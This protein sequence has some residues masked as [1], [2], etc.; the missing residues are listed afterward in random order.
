MQ[1]H[2]AVL[3]DHPVHVAARGHHA[4][5]G[6]EFRDDARDLAAPA[7]GRQ[8]DDRLAAAREGGA[9]DEV[10]LPADARV[11]AMP[12][13]VGH[14][15]ARQVHLDGRVDGHHA[16]IAPDDRRVVGAVTGVKFDR[17][18]VVHEVEQPAGADDEARRRTSGVH[19]LV[20]VGDDAALDQVDEA[21]GEHL[22]VHAEVVLV[23]QAREHRVG[24]GADAHLQGGAVLDEA[25]DDFADARLDRILRAGAVLGKRAIRV[26]ERVDAV[27]RNGGVAVRARHLL[28]D[29][30]DDEARAVDGGARRI[31]RRAERAEAVG[32]GRG[33]L[34]E[35]DVE[36]HASRR[37]QRR[38]VREEDRH[39]IGAPL[40]DGRA[41]AGAG[42]QGDGVEALGLAGRRPRGVTREV[43]VVETDVLEVVARGEGFEQGRGR[44]GRSLDEYPRAAAHEGEGVGGRDGA[45]APVSV[46]WH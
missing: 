19:L 11:D 16:R 25:G 31:D 41:H 26:D 38:N 28:V 35:R 40:L 2:R 24:N 15:L 39:E 6:G 18:V 5:A 12:E 17:E 21:V 9:A 27:E 10:H 44:R 45:R 43:Q 22:R 3:G 46:A 23:G 30:G 7:G 1:V 32:V 36:R 20:L 29:F 4:G 14:H 42:E 8:R 37:E 33:Q 13:R 34:H